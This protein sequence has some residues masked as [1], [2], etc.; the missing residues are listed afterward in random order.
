[1][2]LSIFITGTVAGSM[3]MG[4]GQS[5]PTLTEI[6]QYQKD[7][8]LCHKEP[9][10]RYNAVS[11]RECLNTA[12]VNRMTLAGYEP[13]KLIHKYNQLM[14]AYAEEYASGWRSQSQ[15]EAAEKKHWQN[16]VKME[17]DIASQQQSNTQA[18][19]ASP[20]FI[21]PNIVSAPAIQVIPAPTIK[22]PTITNC[23]PLGNSINCT[24]W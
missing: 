10:T 11:Q 6:D 3:L 12:L 23:Q 8:T 15:Y 22:N 19:S 24:T 2:R 4:C 18:D 13:M 7:T 1:M 20:I 21:L 16:F 5:T 9:L 14:S 17:A